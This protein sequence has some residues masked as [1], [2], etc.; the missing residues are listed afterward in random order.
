MKTSSNRSVLWCS[1]FALALALLST[2]AA[3]AQDEGLTPRQEGANLE[4]NLRY[5]LNAAD[6]TLA[7][8]VDHAGVFCPFPGVLVVNPAHQATVLKELKATDAGDGSWVVPDPETGEE[9]NAKVQFAAAVYDDGSASATSLQAQGLPVISASA[10]SIVPIFWPRCWA[11]RLNHI[12]GTFSNCGPGG[13]QN[14]F[15]FLTLRNHWVCRWQPG[16]ICLEFL[17]PVC[18]LNQYFCRDC[19]GPIIGSWIF[20]RWVCAL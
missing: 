10:V 12:C 2:G 13:C 17:A 8:A 7:L 6:G 18:R 19:S 3:T 15:R 4:E 9:V 1:L 14:G 20:S 11:I 16:F 5:G